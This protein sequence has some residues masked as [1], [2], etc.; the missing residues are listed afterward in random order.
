VPPLAP[1]AFDRSEEKLACKLL[2]RVDGSLRGLADLDEVTVRITHVAAQFVAVIIEGLGEELSAFLGPL[3]IACVDPFAG[4]TADQALSRNRNTAR[5]RAGHRACAGVL[6]LER[7]VLLGS[8][9]RLSGAMQPGFSG[10]QT[11]L[12]GKK[13]TVYLERSGGGAAHSDP[14]S[15][16]YDD[17][18]RRS[19]AGALNAW[20]EDLK[21]RTPRNTPAEDRWVDAEFADALRTWPDDNKRIE[22]LEYSIEHARQHLCNSFFGVRIKRKI[23][24]GWSKVPS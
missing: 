21:R 10:D 17:S 15:A 9:S 13:A 16:K 4:R 19:V 24:S 20:C 5:G 22:R 11:A 7:T 12:P 1:C 6:D 14:R 3:F 23:H 2:E 18:W 8:R